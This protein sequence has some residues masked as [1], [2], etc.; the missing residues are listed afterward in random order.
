MK[1]SCLVQVCEIVSIDAV[2]IIK[3]KG[4]MFEI[5][6]ERKYRKYS[7][8][9][10]LASM[11]IYF[12]NREESLFPKHSQHSQ[13]TECRKG[14]SWDVHDTVVAQYPER[15]G[16]ALSGPGEKMFLAI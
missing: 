12:L 2:N 1:G 14:I 15:E 16:R 8:G 9:C 13:G 4:R 11:T 5:K 6:K 10:L 3:R 7:E